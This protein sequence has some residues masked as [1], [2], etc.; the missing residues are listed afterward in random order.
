MAYINT[1]VIIFVVFLILVFILFKKMVES[2]LLT[3]I[4]I[5]LI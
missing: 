4:K 1:Y 2:V 3:S 5:I